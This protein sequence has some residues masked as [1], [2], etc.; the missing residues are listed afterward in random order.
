MSWVRLPK[1]VSDVEHYPNRGGRLKIIA[2][3]ED[4]QLTVK[5]LKRLRLPVSAQARARAR[6]LPLFQAA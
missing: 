5:I 1:H 3:I 4:P 2:S 6:R